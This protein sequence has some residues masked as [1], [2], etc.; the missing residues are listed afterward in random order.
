MFKKIA[1]ALGFSQGPL[2]CC[3]GKLN[4][5]KDFILI[6]PDIREVYRFKEWMDTGFGRE[7]VK[8]MPP[9]VVSVPHRMLLAF[10]QQRN[11]VVASIWDSS[12][13]GGLRRF[14]FAFF[15]AIHRNVLKDHYNII[16]ILLPV[17]KALE[18]Y[19]YSMGDIKDVSEFYSK[20]RGLRL[21]INR[22][23]SETDINERLEHTRVKALI[24]GLFEKD[25]E[26]CWAR[27]LHNIYSALSL[28]QFLGSRKP[29]IALRLPL[30]SS[31]DISMQVE[32]WIRFIKANSPQP[33]PIPTV[34]FPGKNEAKSLCFNVLWRDPRDEDARL[35]GDNV[36]N[37]QHVID[38]TDCSQF[39]EMESGGLKTKEDLKE[40]TL[41]EFA[42]RFRGDATVQSHL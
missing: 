29:S 11:V 19:Y 33:L 35:L 12:D 21:E 13:A 37:Y 20:F 41:A 36:D 3:Y 30:V 17:W 8:D 22:M 38:L 14:P 7:W 9:P 42:N 23:E 39:T 31:M 5:Y 27:L 6:G 28:Q 16:S 25:G 34:F 40:K 10:P 2:V 18:G 32:M 1:T 24:D 15:V 26:E 4:I